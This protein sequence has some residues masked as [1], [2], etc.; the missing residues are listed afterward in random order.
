MLRSPVGALSLNFLIGYSVSLSVFGSFWI[1]VLKLHGRY[2]HAGLV[3]IEDLLQQ[4]L[5]VLLDL[6]FSRRQCFVDLQLDD[7]GRVESA[8]AIFLQ[9]SSEQ[10][11]DRRRN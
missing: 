8:S 7:S 9:T 2:L 5:S 6:R 11:R 4:I 1:D 10:P 3:L